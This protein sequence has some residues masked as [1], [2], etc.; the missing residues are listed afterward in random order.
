MIPNR[1]PFVFLQ[2]CALVNPVVAQTSPCLP[3]APS[4]LFDW[5]ASGYGSGS[6]F[7]RVVAGNFSGSTDVDGKAVVVHVDDEL[8]V[9]WGVNYQT[10]IVTLGWTPV[11]EQ[12]IADIAVLP[13]GIATG[14]DGLLVSDA[15]GLHLVELQGG[16]SYTSTALFTG[17]PWTGV[18]RV[19]AADI[20]GDG[21]NEITGIASDGVTVLKAKKTSGSWATTSFVAP[22]AVLDFEAFEWTQVLAGK[23]LAVLMADRLAIFRYDGTLLRSFWHTSAHGQVARVRVGGTS[24]VLAWSRLASGSG[25]PELVTVRLN[26]A[27]SGQP[28]EFDVCGATIEVDPVTL[29]GADYNGDGLD[30]LLL[31]YEEDETG[32]VAV[33][34]GQSGWY[35]LGNSD[36][37]DTLPLVPG[38]IGVGTGNDCIPFFGDLDGDATADIVAGVSTAGT[39]EVWRNAAYKRQLL[40][41]ETTS[42]S[43]VQTQTEIHPV[44]AGSGNHTELYFALAVPQE[45]NT[46]THVEVVLFNQE[47]LNSPTVNLTAVYHHLFT[48]QF[49]G[50]TAAPYQYV[51]LDGLQEGFEWTNRMHY[52]M[53]YRF[54]NASGTNP[55]ITFASG[56]QWF[57]GGWTVRAAAPDPEVADMANYFMM[58]NGGIGCFGINVDNSLPDQSTALG[59]YV[60]MTRVPPF[61]PGGTPTVPLATNPVAAIIYTPPE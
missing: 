48:L 51:V 45:F 3:Y 21:T 44:L 40:A 35:D 16:S 31:T 49:N 56:S 5:P 47:A 33:C 43:I 6:N 2:L 34:T 20:D 53:R 38:T 50:S 39:A 10:S 59:A 42:A 23:E 11:S 41:D 27:S 17:N 19:Q 26:T 1:L 36:Y 58:N 22:G 46:R 57:V 13:D 28:L 8:D 52:Y 12:L 29:S 15:D 25:D 30:D 37:Y 60:P 55:N 18:K 61:P 7:Q 54:V 9:L 32:V 14:K 24:D 4:N